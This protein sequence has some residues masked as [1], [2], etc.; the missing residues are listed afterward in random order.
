MLEKKHRLAKDRDV[1]VTL[2]RGR[3]FFSPFFT[4]KFF[5]GPSSPRFA[6]VVSTKVSKKAVTR[7][8]IKRV[9]REVVKLS[10]KSF[11]SG[12]YV[13]MVKPS[14]AKLP[15]DAML[16]EFSGLLQKSRLII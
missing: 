15:E 14:S 8:R 12:D 2:A 9:L 10:L 6:F 4:L 7:N 3:S 16:K 11:K 1:R 5:T 13:V